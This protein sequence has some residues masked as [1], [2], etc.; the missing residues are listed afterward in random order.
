MRGGVKG[1]LTSYVF[2]TLDAYYSRTGDAIAS[3]T[4]G[5][6]VLNICGRAQ[7]IFNINGGTVHANG[8]EASVATKLEVAGGALTLGANGANQSAT[9]VKVPFTYAG[10][11]L[12]GSLVAQI[13]HWTASANLDYFHTV[14]S[15]ADVFLHIA[16]QGQWGGGQDTTTS[17]APFNELSSLNNVDM[18]VGADYKKFQ[19]AVFA[20]NLT[21]ETVALLKFQTSGVALANRYNEPRTIGASLSYK[22]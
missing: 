1:N 22:W 2:F 7:Q 3:V 18:R 13:P 17:I 19:F 10:A 6:T 16:Y 5:C 20:Q 12:V 8:V 11:P 15:D 14:A 21:N 9:Y 4:D